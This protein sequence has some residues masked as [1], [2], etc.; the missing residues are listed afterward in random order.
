MDI[1]EN[2]NDPGPSH[3][4]PTGE[5]AVILRVLQNM[6]KNHKK[7]TKLLQQGLIAAPKEQKSGNISDFGRL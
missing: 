7:Q 5:N 6:M 4:G 1:R 3:N 2:R